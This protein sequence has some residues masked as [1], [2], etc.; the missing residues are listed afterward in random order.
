MPDEPSTKMVL[1]GEVVGVHGV[2]GWLKLHSFTDPIDR[3]FSYEH[4]F[5]DGQVK[6]V[7]ASKAKSKP[8][9]CQLV[10]CDDRDQAVSLVGKPI[11]VPREALPEL[12]D[13]EYYWC[14]LEGLRVENEAGEALGF[15]QRLFSTG[16][17]DVMVATE[18]ADGTGE[19]RLIPWVMGRYVKKVDLPDGKAVVDWDPEF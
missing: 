4:W 12:P 17:N 18:R 9:L 10:G 7:E 13:G 11:E 8:L 14:D 2:R 1:V 15:V 6:R 16:A 19:Q 3:I 5:V